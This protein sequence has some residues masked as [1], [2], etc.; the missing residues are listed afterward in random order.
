MKF[1]L[2]FLIFI[3]STIHAY[4][5]PV[6]N[7]QVS[8]GIYDNKVDLEW[9][10]VPEAEFYTIQRAY[11]TLK[12]SKLGKIIP[13]ETNTLVTQITT[14]NYTDTNIPFGQHLYIITAYKTNITQLKESNRERKRRER[15]NDKKHILTP[16]PMVT[17]IVMITN[18]TDVGHRKIT[19][20]EFF[21]E[22]QKTI[23]SS[24]PRINTMKMLNFFGEKKTGWRQGYLVYKTTGIIQKPFRVM[25]KYTD[26]VDQV[27]S[28]NGTYEVQIFKL[29][30][31][32]GKLVG[33]I[34]VD[35][36]YK[37]SVTHNLIIDKGQAIGGTYEVQQA[38]GPLVSLP[39]DTAAHPLDDSEYEN[40]LK[41]SLLEVEE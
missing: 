22:F 33:T 24:L 6:Y 14:T 12:N 36:I 26:F 17:N 4:V 8:D 25:I 28:I 7:L 32:E 2:Y 40:A 38:G 23:E 19:D 39:W 37:G 11:N 35:G 15:E 20:Q 41:S 9:Y 18:M 34:N 1:L 3:T 30:A 10:S 16:I 29:F 21:L 5:T 27:L 13:V 31:Q